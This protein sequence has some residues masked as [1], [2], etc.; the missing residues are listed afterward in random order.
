[1]LVVSTIAI[2]WGVLTQ[3][4]T[5]TPWSPHM[6][7]WS[8]DPLPVDH[9]HDATPLVRQGAAVFQAKQ[10]RNCHSAGGSGGERGPALDA[11][12]TRLTIDQLRFKVVTGGG[13]MPAYGK[14]L[15]PP[16]IEAL[17][18]F[19][20]TLHPANEPPAYDASQR[21][22][23]ASQPANGIASA[24]RSLAYQGSAP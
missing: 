23:E 16:E 22:A 18:D 1:V 20:E 4:G 11:V 7:A 3:L 14:N 17:V 2:S 15:S 21:T 24:G 6:S 5:T 8:G 13:N 12:A 10:C 9:V 19:L